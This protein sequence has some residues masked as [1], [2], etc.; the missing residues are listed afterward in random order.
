M[1]MAGDSSVPALLSLVTL[2]AI[3]AQTDAV[4]VPP[5]PK[6]PC[7]FE[8][9]RLFYPCRCTAGSD[10]GVTLVCA[11]AN[12]ASLSV[13]FAN[14]AAMEL[15]VES[16][17]IS[18][19]KFSRLY[20]GLLYALDVKKLIVEDTP[21]KSIE[22]QTFLGVNRTLEELQLV[23][24]HLS[25]FPKEALEILG[26]LTFLNID[27]HQFTSLPVGS[28]GGLIAENLDRISIVNGNLSDLAIE[29]LGVC[30]KLK[31]VDLHGNRLS[32]LKKNQFKG[33]RNVEFLDLSYNG[34]VKIDASHLSDLNKLSRFNLSHNSIAD[35]T[36]GAFARNTVLRSLN[37]SHNKLKKIDSNSF[38]GMRFIR[39]LYLSDNEIS[40]V[41]RDTFGAV[42]RIGVV[43]LARN[44][45]SKIDFQMFAKLQY[46]ER[47]DVSDNYVQ[48]IQN[49][50]F[51]DLYLVHI[52]LS[53]NAISKIE[54][55]AFENCVNITVLDLSYNKISEFGP[56]VFDEVSFATELQL[57][58]NN[59]TDLSKVP[60]AN[61][62]GL[63]TLNVTNNQLRTIPR[64]TFPKLYEL[65][66][67]DVSH[68][69]ISE[70]YNGVFQTLFGLRYLN[71]SYN[72][73]KDIKSATFGPVPTLLEL[74]MS[75]N[76]LS[77]V[78]RGALNRLV[79]LQQLSVAYNQLTTIF[80]I[81]SA[82]SRLYLNYNEIATIPARAWPSANALLSLDLSDNFLQDNLSKGSFLNLVTLQKLD[83]SR[84]FMTEPPWESLSDTPSLQFLHLEGNNL[85]SLGKGAFGKLTTVF[86]VNVAANQIANVSVKAFDGLL[87]LIK[88][89]LSHNQLDEIPNGAFQGLVSLRSL[90]LSNNNLESLDNKT[91][92]VLDDCL[93]LEKVNLSNNRISFITKKTFP[94]DPWQPYKLKEIDLSYN[95]MP[96][97]TFDL[98]YGTRKVEVLN[99]SHNQINEI[100]KGVTSNLTSLRELDLSFNELTDL[101]D[102]NTFDLPA[103]LKKLNLRGNRLETLPIDQIKTLDFIDLRDNQLGYYVEVTNMVKNGSHVLYAGNHINCDCR[104]RPLKRWIHDE[105]SRLEDWSNVR[106]YLPPPVANQA[107][108]LVDERRMS[109]GDLV[110]DGNEDYDTT[111]DIKFREIQRGPNGKISLTWYVT[112]KED[113]ADFTLLVKGKKNEG[114]R[115]STLLKKNLAYSTRSAVLSN[116]P[117][118]NGP[119]ELCIVAISSEGKEREPHNLQCRKL[120]S[121]D[122]PVDTS[123]ADRPANNFLIYAMLLV[124]SIR[125]QHLR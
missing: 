32:V 103:S 66:T 55:G 121:E 112:A 61:M 80:Q 92:G 1:V 51:K 100:R 72:L 41:G 59:L 33:Q 87:Q 88:L 70:I 7:P 37:L 39:Q 99:L 31:S 67:I 34:I 14:V 102:S 84:N 3:W 98:T 35:I 117:S 2:L 106:C 107:L 11:N 56:R 62:T 108:L 119:L 85:T 22:P 83:L 17:T 96:V 79:S 36:R 64:N 50:A 44:K 81:P 104:L 65:H 91:H 12:L 20:G 89:N 4:Y 53:H 24:T 45:L 16:L 94:S 75:H 68:N 58:Y 54:P 8:R 48:E 101:S 49:L 118:E 63:K 122:P 77:E 124:F 110:S 82:L 10:V 111:P 46:A 30:K 71:M 125:I 19:S 120:N 25:S 6:Y 69:E 47:I 95:L 23:R 43:D 38:R 74:D 9:P 18:S 114:N 15:P 60:L 76:T 90:D 105:P 116:F 52:N 40:S 78:S 113:I 86:E 115:E 21:L 5:G 13:A 29:T 73:L 123:S 27:G 109:C 93:S 26:K 97:V 28:L 57:S 42:S